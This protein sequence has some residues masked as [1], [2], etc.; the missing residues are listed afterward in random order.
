MVIIFKVI[1]ILIFALYMFNDWQTFP[2]LCEDLYL[3]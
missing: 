3:M 2:N 1:I